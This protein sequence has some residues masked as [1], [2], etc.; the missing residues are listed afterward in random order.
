MGSKAAGFSARSRLDQRGYAALR[1]KQPR[2]LMIF[3]NLIG[4]TEEALHP[5]QGVRLC[6]DASWC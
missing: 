2:G 1:A 6:R 3:K 5:R 4:Y